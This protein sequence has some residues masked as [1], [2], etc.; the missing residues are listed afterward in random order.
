MDVL[1]D[2]DNH[3]GLQIWSIRTLSSSQVSAIDDEMK[4]YLD[5][6]N[7]CVLPNRKIDVFLFDNFAYLEGFTFNNSYFSTINYI[8]T[9]IIWWSV[10]IV[11]FF[12]WF[13]MSKEGMFPYKPVQWNLFFNSNFRCFCSLQNTWQKLIFPWFLTR[14]LHLAVFLHFD[15]TAIH[16][17]WHILET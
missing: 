17:I 4:S 1:L 7:K 15:R 11:W 6:D 2:L 14:W 5:K 13:E 12:S 3:L 8:L 16:I 9:D 10:C